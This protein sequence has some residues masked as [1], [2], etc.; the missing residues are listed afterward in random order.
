MS[1]DSQIAGTAVF[2]PGVLALVR[3]DPGPA[4]VALR[5][6]TAE[7][8]DELWVTHQ[9]LAADVG[10]SSLIGELARA[11]LRAIDKVE[12]LS[13]ADILDEQLLNTLTEGKGT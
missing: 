6:M 3:G 1:G 8:R 5:A 7:Q 9:E 2:M 4:E 13:R 10:A 11:T 12:G